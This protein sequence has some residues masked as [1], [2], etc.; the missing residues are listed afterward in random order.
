MKTS[1]FEGCWARSLGGCD[2]KSKEHPFSESIMDGEWPVI[3]DGRRLL[4]RWVS[5]GNLCS[6]HNSDL[7][8][9][10]AEAKRFFEAQAAVAGNP[11]FLNRYPDRGTT[12]FDGWKL[13][14]FFAKVLIGFAEAG[15]GFDHSKGPVFFEKKQELVNY[16]FGQSHEPPRYPYGLW[17]RQA[18][19]PWQMERNVI[20]TQIAMRQLAWWDVQGGHWSKL[21]QCPVWLM[22]KYVG[23][24]PVQFGLFDLW[25]APDD[26]KQDF[27]PRGESVPLPG[28]M[29]DYR[30]IKFG[31]ETSPDAEPTAEPPYVFEITWKPD[32]D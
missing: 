29:K 27:D 25:P 10:D 21:H 20:R 26:Y 13:E 14:R 2:F 28:A 19:K 17:I 11:K 22:L 4:T 9:L 8:D 30:P 18:P 7:S 6:K 24:M 1:V 12:F 3:R 15:I 5:V 23:V 32:A 16:V 31:F